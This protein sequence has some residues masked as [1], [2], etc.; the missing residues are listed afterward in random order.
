MV[1]VS[2]IGCDRFTDARRREERP[3]GSDRELL[4][5]GGL[6]PGPNAIL[7]G[8]TFEEWLGSAS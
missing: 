5:N 8:P 4:A 7:G 1:I 6:L 2:I 3:R